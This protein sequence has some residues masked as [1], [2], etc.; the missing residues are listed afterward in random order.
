MNDLSIL[1]ARPEESLL[2]YD[3]TVIEII[4]KS[5]IVEVKLV[6]HKATDKIKA[7]KSLVQ[8]RCSITA[9]Q[10]ILDR[11]VLC[12]HLQIAT[13][14]SNCTEAFKTGPFYIC[15]WSVPLGAT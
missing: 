3:Y 13:R 5:A 11:N 7:L 6:N 4:G 14:W 15:S 1:I 10:H 12:F 2:Q 8:Q 9:N